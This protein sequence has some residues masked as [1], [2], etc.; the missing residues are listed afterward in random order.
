[1]NT[2][3][4]PEEVSRYI[5][6]VM[7]KMHGW[8]SVAKAE[9]LAR[10]VISAKP[11]V[12]IEIGVY[13]G[14]SLFAIATALKAIGH[15]HIIGIDPWETESSIEGYEGENRTWWSLL[16][17]NMIYKQCTDHLKMLALEGHCDVFVGR[18]DQA[19]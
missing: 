7:P 9:H 16:D 13:S 15:G 10:S 5:N 3:A 18:S 11:M 19:L 6:D 8:C 4:L 14:R 12:C 1:M 17:H 2:P